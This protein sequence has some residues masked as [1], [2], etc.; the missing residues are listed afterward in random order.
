[1]SEEYHA[2]G[3]DIAEGW[4]DEIAH[5]YVV[6]DMLKL[7]PEQLLY[8]YET[9]TGFDGRKRTV[10]S[11]VA[12]LGSGWF[13]NNGQTLVE[14][15]DWVVGERGECAVSLKE[16]VEAELQGIVRPRAEMSEGFIA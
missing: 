15:V 5:Y 11:F 6:E 14:T 4:G 3:R 12:R 8:L 2:Y 1:M 16:A 13:A 7:N 9:V 10:E